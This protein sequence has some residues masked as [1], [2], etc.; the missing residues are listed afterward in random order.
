MSDAWVLWGEKTLPGGDLELDY[1]SYDQEALGSTHGRI[2]IVVEK[3]GIPVYKARALAKHVRS[4]GVLPTNNGFVISTLL[5]SVLEEYESISRDVQFC[6]VKVIAKDDIVEGYHLVL[7]H[8]RV[9]CV[10]LESEGIIAY[11]KYGGYIDIYEAEYFEYLPNC[12]DGYLIARDA[13]QSRQLIFATVLKERFAKIDKKI[14]FRLPRDMCEPR[15][16]C[17]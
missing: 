6:P 10:D 11:K 4:R 7:V 16:K 3:V 13:T 12:L 17:I 9:K 2:P 5:K 14:V 1:E 8:R 15:W